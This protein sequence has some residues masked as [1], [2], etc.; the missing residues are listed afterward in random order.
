MDLFRLTP[1]TRPVDLQGPSGPVPVAT[2]NTL[3]GNGL[4]GAWPRQEDH[5]IH[6]KQVVPSTSMLEFLGVYM[7]FGNN[8]E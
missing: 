8:F 3:P 4:D 7:Y 2:V 5:E 1:K 6:D